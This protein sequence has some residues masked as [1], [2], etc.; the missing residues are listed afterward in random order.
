MQSH[1]FF[2]P[3]SFISQ[4]Q[5]YCEDIA[6]DQKQW[7]HKGRDKKEIKEQREFNNCSFLHKLRYE[8]CYF[9]KIYFLFLF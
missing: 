2:S 4:H 8:I 5:N 1:T 6:I 7:T 9:I 3:K